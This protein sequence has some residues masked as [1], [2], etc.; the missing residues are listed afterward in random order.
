[1]KID[2]T[3]DQ[4]TIVEGVLLADTFWTK[5]SGFMFRK[6]PHVPGFVFEGASSIH[7]NFMCFTL[8]LAFI[9]RESRVIKIVRGMK[10]WRFTWFYPKTRF[11]LEVPAGV[12][13]P[14]LKVGDKLELKHV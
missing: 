8:D 2:V 5:L 13:P 3:L 12:L 11:V 7:T 6:S 9:D 14:D 1:M 10:P 4:K